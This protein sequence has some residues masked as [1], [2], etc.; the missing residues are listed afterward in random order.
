MKEYFIEYRQ[1]KKGD[2]LVLREGGWGSTQLAR[3]S[4]E[5]EAMIYAEELEADE[6]RQARLA[7]IFI[8]AQEEDVNPWDHP[9]FWLMEES[10]KAKELVSGF[11]G[12]ILLSLSAPDTKEVDAWKLGAVEEIVPEGYESPYRFGRLMRNMLGDDSATIWRYN[13]RNIYF[14]VRENQAVLYDPSKRKTQPEISLRPKDD[15]DW[16]EAVDFMNTPPDDLITIAEAAKIAGVTIQAI[17]NRIANGSIR[18]WYNAEAP[19]SRQ[20]AR[21]VS[22]SEIERIYVMGKKRTREH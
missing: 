9:A 3:F 5:T 19:G 17:T 12:E 4:T 8:P 21:L 6:K 2:W 20:G 15:M 14:A 18:H 7:R 16:F 11:Y 1:T 22:K 13:P 10:G